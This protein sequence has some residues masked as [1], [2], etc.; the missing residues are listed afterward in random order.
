M[1]NLLESLAALIQALNASNPLAMLVLLVL[2]FLLA[3]CLV[4]RKAFGT[5]DRLAGRGRRQ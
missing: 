4:L 3:S 1:H 5:I 2:A